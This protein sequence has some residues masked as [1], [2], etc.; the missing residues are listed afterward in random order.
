[1]RTLIV[2][3]NYRTGPLVVDCLRSLAPEVAGAP[4]TRAVVVDNDS[5]DGSVEHVA[6]ALARAGWNAWAEIVVAP[7]NGGFACGNNVGLRAG[8][9]RV[10]VPEA[11]W[12]VNPDTIVFPGA[13]R[14]MTDLLRR[15]PRAGI[16]GSRIEGPAGEP[17][18]AAHRAPTLMSEFDVGARVGVITRWLSRHNLSP[19]GVDHPH[20]CEWVSG[21][22]LM[23]RRAV[24]DTVGLLD[25]G[26]FL[27]FEEVDF[28]TRARRAGW[29]V[30]H[31][32]A[33]TVVHLEAAATGV[34][35]CRRTPPYWFASRRRYFVRNYGG[36]YAALA[37]LAR[38][39]GIGL[40]WI[41]RRLTH[42]PPGDPPHFLGDLIRHS[43]LR[44]RTPVGV[45]G[46]A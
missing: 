17:E 38:I 23:L 40:G 12:L 26:Y 16:V 25:D 46:T 32:P 45:E 19:A 30:W 10:P 4:G 20:P 27:Y 28:C 13:L 24:L 33:A 34:Q 2:I 3:V 14:A 43:L 36:T 5:R 15:N 8:L 11:F 22:S 7:R 9:A 37:D 44:R 35:G 39:S 41:Y 21:A 42:V 6:E 31:Q 1:M 18:C 29:E